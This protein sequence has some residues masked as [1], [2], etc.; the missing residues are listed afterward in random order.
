MRV[1]AGPMCDI[2]GARKT[3]VLLLLLGVPGMIIF[4]TSQS[5]FMFTLGRVFIGLSLATFV[6]CQVWC[7]QFFDRKVVG[8]ANA[9][10]GGWGNVGGG[11]TLLVMPQIMKALV[12]GTGDISLSW[13]VAFILPMLMHIGSMIF[14]WTGKDLPDGSYKQLETA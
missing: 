14:I 11:V 2:W 7:S 4:M 12:D 13:R 10:A 8:T 1:A 5:A 3:F 6:T 9:T